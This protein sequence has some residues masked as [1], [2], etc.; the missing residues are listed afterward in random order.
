M[1]ESINTYITWNLSSELVGTLREYTPVNRI[2]NTEVSLSV[3]C[4]NGQYGVPEQ[5]SQYSYSLRAGWSS[6]GIMVE[7]RFFAAIQSIHGAHPASCTMG[8][9]SFLGLNWLGHSI[10]HPPPCSVDV[11]G[12]VE[13]Y[14]YPFVL[15]WQVI[16][17]TL[18]F[19]F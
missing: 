16:E 3:K 4:K 17:W 12:R 15:S 13:L 8:A 10:N 11:T 2:A 14:H 1:N 19:N 5:C 7:M 18:T 9:G 6:D